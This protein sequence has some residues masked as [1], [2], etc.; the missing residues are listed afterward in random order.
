MS[1]AVA[2]ADAAG[3][4]FGFFFLGW[5]GGVWVVSVLCANAGGV[6]DSA[7][8]TT[9]KVQALRW[10]GRPQPRAPQLK[11]MP[12]PRPC[13][14]R[15]LAQRVAREAVKMRLPRK[16]VMGETSSKSGREGGNDDPRDAT[17]E[18]ACRGNHLER[19]R[20]RH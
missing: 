18:I 10:F 8:S 2:V 12:G 3:A 7:A 17:L 19:L 15:A 4:V 11:N 5:A 14:S 9:A 16:R 1:L 6:A 20:V 13:P